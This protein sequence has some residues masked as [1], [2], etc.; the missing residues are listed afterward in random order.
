MSAMSTRKFVDRDG[1]TLFDIDAAVN[2]VLDATKTKYDRAIRLY[3]LMV[4]IHLCK[5]SPPSSEANSGRGG[6]KVRVKT[7]DLRTARHFAV[8]RIMEHL[9]QG[10]HERSRPSDIAPLLSAF[11]SEPFR[12]L[13]DDVFIT[14]G[15][16]KRVRSLPT[17]RDFQR[18]IKEAH[19]EDVGKLIDFSMRFVPNPLK[20]RRKGRITMACEIVV[21]ASEE[22]LKEF[23]VH[24]RKTVLKTRW[25]S[26]KP[27]AVVHYMI[28]IQKLGMRPPTLAKDKFPERLINAVTR[29]K[30]IRN[31]FLIYNEVCGRLAERGY[32]FQRLTLEGIPIPD[33]L[34]IDPLPPAMQRL[35]DEYTGSE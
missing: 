30:R 6:F 24:D 27:V 19:V 18:Q 9:Q 15:G 22:G 14:N 33:R 3:E 7:R 29:S 28:H 10:L 4:V 12:H 5:G 34:I 8:M 13:Y 35:V 31:F 25:R 20:P 11:V 26:L 23:H 2:E 16:W 17:Q 1:I 32:N 21:R